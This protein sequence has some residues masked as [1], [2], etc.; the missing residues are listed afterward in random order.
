MPPR[1]TS[2]WTCAWGALGIM[3]DQVRTEKP[4]L[5]VIVLGTGP[6]DRVEVLRDGE[7]VY[8]EMPAKNPAEARFSLGGSE[9]EE[10]R[11]LLCAA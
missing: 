2:C 11:L 4:E 6:M 8:T 5:D 3:G 1:T 9:A 7:V 10:D